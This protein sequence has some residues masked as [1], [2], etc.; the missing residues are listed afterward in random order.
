MIHT[1]RDFNPKTSCQRGEKFESSLDQSELD[2]NETDRMTTNCKKES[3][4]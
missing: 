2:P 3:R 1:K 4:Q